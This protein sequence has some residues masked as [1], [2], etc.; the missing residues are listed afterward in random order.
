[1]EKQKHIHYQ[2][3]LL[4]GQKEDSQITQILTSLKI[5]LDMDSPDFIRIIPKDE[6]SIEDSRLIIKKSS[7]SPLFSKNKVILVENFSNPSLQGQNSLLKILEEPPLSTL[8]ILLS[9]TKNN[10]LPTI[11]SR[12]ITVDYHTKPSSKTD[13]ISIE[14]FISQITSAELSLGQKLMLLD[15]SKEADLKVLIKDLQITLNKPN[16]NKSELFLAKSLLDINSL[17]KVNVKSR[18]ILDNIIIALDQVIK[19]TKTD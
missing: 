4:I 3:Y 9:E 16:L 1:M 15:K 13:A 8:I 2:P 10:I 18:L 17:T 11:L 7:L 6:F 12:V 5:D 19:S 14:A